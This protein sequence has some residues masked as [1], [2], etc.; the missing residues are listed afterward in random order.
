MQD[1][2]AKDANLGKLVTWQ[3][4][5]NMQRPLCSEEIVTVDN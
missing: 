1:A 2:M 4:G 3:L 5:D